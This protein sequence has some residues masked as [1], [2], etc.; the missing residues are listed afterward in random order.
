MQQPSSAT[1]LRGIF[2]V[3]EHDRS[4]QPNGVYKRSAPSEAVD[5]R[6]VARIVDDA[7]QVRYPLHMRPES[8]IDTLTGDS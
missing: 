7:A 8:P 4:E 2:W 1:S 6:T 3:K 5:P